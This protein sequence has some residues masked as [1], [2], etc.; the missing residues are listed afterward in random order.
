M[1]NTTYTVRRHLI[2]GTQDSPQTILYSDLTDIDGNEL[3]AEFATAPTVAIFPPHA[4]R[5]A[6][7]IYGSITVTQFQVA[8]SDIGKQVASVR[9]DFEIIGE[10]AT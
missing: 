6:N 8:M 4:D 5:G 3:P 1:A 7:V 9:T 2:T 10:A